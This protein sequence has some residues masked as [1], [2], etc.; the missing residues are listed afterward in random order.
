MTM[1]AP[2]PPEKV[3]QICALYLAGYSALMTSLQVGV[4]S[5]T[6]L[7]T[8]RRNKITVRPRGSSVPG[9]RHPAWKGDQVGYRAAHSRV[10]RTRGRPQ[11]CTR[12]QTT[13][14]SKIYDWA[15]LTGN[16]P[17]PDDYARMCRS[18]HVI[19]DRARR[20]AQ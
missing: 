18:C 15:N 6:V 13:D 16:Y 11:H 9:L 8:L 19:F 5:A 20:A 7:T 1:T 17:D 12:C 3:A 2:T 4:S 10:S 14:P